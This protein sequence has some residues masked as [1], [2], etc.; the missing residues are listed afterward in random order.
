VKEEDEKGMK[1]RD[2]RKIGMKRSERRG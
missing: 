2:E 1:E